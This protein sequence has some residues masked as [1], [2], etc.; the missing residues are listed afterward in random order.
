MRPAADRLAAALEQV[1][2]RP[3]RVP[4][5]ANVDAEPN[6]DATRVK[7][8]LVRQITGR[9]RWGASVR[10]ALHMGARRGHGKVLTGL[11]KRIAPDL[12]VSAVG[13]PEDL[14]LIQ[15]ADALSSESPKKKCT[16]VRVRADSGACPTVTRQESPMN[17]GTNTTP[18]QTQGPGDQP[19]IVLPRTTGGGLTIPPAEPGCTKS[20]TSVA[21][22]HDEQGVRLTA[23]VPPSSLAAFKATAL[24]VWRWVL[25]LITG[26][27]GYLVGRAP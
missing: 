21:F 9:V 15:V 3:L 24:R 14:D 25:P 18:P 26:Y 17:V 5:I 7:D 4:V 22:E 11:I 1:E 6:T 8:L 2:V 20:R 23:T 27:L 13:S 10:K 19:V 16:R 12:P